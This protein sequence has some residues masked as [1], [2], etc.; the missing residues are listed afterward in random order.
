MLI[1]QEDR[2]LPRRIAPDICVYSTL[3]RRDPIS[4]AVAS[5]GPPPL[6]IEVA[7]PSTATHNDTNLLEPAAKPQLYERIGVAE[8]LVFDPTG[9]SVGHP[10]WALRRGP[11]GFIPWLPE[12]DGRWH[13]SLGVSFA[14]Q[15]PLLRV[16]DREGRLVPRTVEMDAQ[17][18]GQEQ[19]IAALEAELRRLRGD[20]R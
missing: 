9:E 3:A 15:C 18:T 8:Y 11:N 6:T 19:R 2:A 16:Y 17:I 14:Q 7:S 13:S 20:A 1:R 5:E 4:L 10:L 12:P